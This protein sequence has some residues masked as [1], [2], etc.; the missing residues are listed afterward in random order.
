MNENI[1]A[2][3]ICIFQEPVQ[4]KRYTLNI[5]V[6]LLMSKEG[7]LKKGEGRKGQTK[8]ERSTEVYDLLSL[9][10]ALRG[11]IHIHIHIHN[12]FIK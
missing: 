2:Y 3:K 12:Y 7:E 6:W 8:P 1:Y 9:F 4:T 5:A 10:S 11:K